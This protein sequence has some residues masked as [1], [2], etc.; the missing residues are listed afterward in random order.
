MSIVVVVTAQ[1]ECSSVGA[2][3]TVPRPGWK[4]LLCRKNKWETAG[5]RVM[6]ALAFPAGRCLGDRGSHWPHRQ[7]FAGKWCHINRSAPIS[8]MGGGG[9]ERSLCSGTE[10]FTDKQIHKLSHK[11]DRGLL[12]L[13]LILWTV[14]FLIFFFYEGPWGDT[15]LFSHTHKDEFCARISS[16][17]YEFLYLQC[18]H[19]PAC[20]SL[21]VTAVFETNSP[22][23]TI[24]PSHT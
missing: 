21:H 6:A 7:C 17:L 20:L 5:S 14:T 8:R 10:P 18:A 9:R 22:S 13:R 16:N 11:V 24:K 23:W 1:C 15:S 19:V 12:W 4:T 2:S 3:F